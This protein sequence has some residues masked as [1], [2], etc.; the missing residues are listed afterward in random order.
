M[1]IV[2]VWLS[3]VD[4]LCQ[5]ARFQ[6]RRK[7]TMK[8][9]TLIPDCMRFKIFSKVPSLSDK[10]RQHLITKTLDNLINHSLPSM[11]SNIQIC[12][13]KILSRIKWN[14]IWSHSLLLYIWWIRKQVLFIL[15]HNFF[16][17][18]LGY[19]MS[20]CIVLYAAIVPPTH[21]WV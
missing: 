5:H 7:M 20:T 16:S 6:M 9:W 3:Q 21:F 8:L 4:K 11:P 12:W 2:H 15:D 18:I 10:I 19:Q 17:N 14:I 1:A 13:F